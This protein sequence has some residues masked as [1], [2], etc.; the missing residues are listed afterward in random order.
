M[1]A[2][3]RLLALLAVC[4]A[5]HG[6]VPPPRPRPA[7]PPPLPPKLAQL[8]EWEDRRS[9]GDGKLEE[10]A[11]TDPEPQ[12][13]ARALLALGRIQDAAVTPSL[14][15]AMQDP[16]AGARAAAAFAAGQLG[17]A[18]EGLAEEPK[19]ALT[20]ALLELEGKEQD[21]A[22]RAAQ[23]EALSKLAS[24][25]A[26]ERLSTRLL[27]TPPEVQGR[28]AL[29]LGVAV[30]RGAA[31]SAN[32]LT[33]LAPL[34]RKDAPVPTRYG[35]AYALAMSKSLAARPSLLL[36]AADDSSD[37]RALCA[38]GL[39]DAGLETD[40]VALRRLLDDG[41]YR[42]AVEATKALAKL[43]ER[44]RPASCP[45]L[46]ALGGLEARVD[47]LEKGDVAA[48][49][50]PLLAL[51]QAGLPLS[52][53]SV[54]S[55]LRQRLAASRAKAAPQRQADFANLDCR[56]AAA[57]DG[58]KGAVEESKGCG[59]G[60]VAEPRRLAQA[61][62][63]ISQLSPKD[64]PG[65]LDA[66]APL[67]AHADP[68]V[69]IAAT[70]VLASGENPKAAEKLRPLL[71]DAD[72]IVA[73]SAAD[74]LGKLKDAASTPQI[75]A[76]AAKVAGTPDLAAGV[77]SAL[78]G[79]KAKEGEGTLRPWLDSPEP[80]VALA[81]AKALT[82]ITGQK[83]V[84]KRVERPTA[85]PLALAPSGAQV[86]LRTEKGSLTV[87]LFT[88]DAPRTA[89]N[90][91]A[92]ARKGYFKNLTFHR[93]VPD[94]VVQGGDPRGDGEGGPGYRI[95]CEVNARPYA[96][97]TVGMA[98]SGKDTGGSQFFAALAPQPHLD[99]RYT[100]FGEVT[101][102]EE[103]LDTLL[104]GDKILEVQVRP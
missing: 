50:Q 89:A 48:G 85:A 29:G 60:A 82:A 71:A 17:L 90:F 53:R 25:A 51:A 73:V 62:R 41:D 66:V 80:S 2:P 24:P 56:F 64:A 35:A 46:G 97:R 37:V 3:F 27:G 13:R 55:S 81:A 87:A 63:M 32:A 18:W 78:E 9:L 38:R 31:L 30:R 22:V 28:A 68:G 12:V 33:A 92:L 26:L 75:L 44:C 77:A 14:I 83:P 6:C 42:V 43:S 49:A 39:G 58:Q 23:L 36:C 4:P 94:F 20:N 8:L 45:A 84:L 91:Y 1:R 99:G 102:G 74:A 88:Q 61:L 67:L 7:A 72:P 70:E 40:A 95:R 93:I 34:I 103:V 47:R 104:E 19:G 86:E 11:L 76:L 96:R 98:L 15:K 79:L 54:L 52:G 69:R 10:L 101:V 21:G 65:R 100:V 59:F 5:L 57:L 16:D